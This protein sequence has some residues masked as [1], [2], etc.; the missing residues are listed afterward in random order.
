MKHIMFNR[1]VGAFLIISICNNSVGESKDSRPVN[2]FV[3]LV[4]KRYYLA[5]R[6]EK[7]VQVLLQ[8]YQRQREDSGSAIWLHGK[9]VSTN[10]LIPHGQASQFKHEVVK[11]LILKIEETQSLKSVQELWSDLVSCK[12]IESDL[13]VREALI[14]ILLLY[15][16]LIHSIVDDFTQDKQ[17]NVRLLLPEKINSELSID[18]LLSLLD[19]MVQQCENSKL[20]FVEALPLILS[21][22][23]SSGLLPDTSDEHID[24][25]DN[26]HGIMALLEES[27]DEGDFALNNSMRF[28]YIQR[29]RNPIMLLAKITTFEQKITLWPK[30]AKGDSFVQLP[31][32]NEAIK[33]CVQKLQQGNGLEPLFQLWQDVTGHRFIADEQF[34]KEFILLLVVTYKALVEFGIGGKVQ[35][36]SMEQIMKLYLLVAALPIKELL[37][38]LDNL[39]EQGAAIFENYEITSS[40]NWK[41]W[42]TKFW[43]IPP[44]IGASLVMNFLL[45]KKVAS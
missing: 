11:K 6:L 15:R 38:E 41:T 4:Q 28:Y 37:N 20:Y 33:N 43:W 36:P 18:K 10:V 30:A 44:I 32:A 16:N 14:A 42:L 17:H 40:Q 9:R 5:H 8:I 34:V 3:H 13:F 29:L 12:Y 22:T 21:K 35:I 23:S 24:L 25:Y 19:S 45:K 26:F 2:D 7:P 27:Y 1:L 39:V 31:L